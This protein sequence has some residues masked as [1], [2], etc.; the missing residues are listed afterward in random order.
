MVLCPAA[1]TDRLSAH[2]LPGEGTDKRRK[3][4]ASEANSDCGPQALKRSAPQD[5][6]NNKFFRI[7]RKSIDTVSICAHNKDVD[8]VS[9]DLCAES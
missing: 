7:L 1:D 5:A 6:A 2:A 8:T 4:Q 3:S 9:K